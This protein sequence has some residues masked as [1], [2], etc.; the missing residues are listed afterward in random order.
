[1]S[2][3]HS[4][5]AASGAPLSSLQKMRICKLAEEAWTAKGRPYFTGDDAPF[6][7]SKHEALTLWRQ[8]EQKAAVDH[9]HLTTCTQVE[10]PRLMSHFLRALGRAEE[11]D[12]WEARGAMDPLRQAQVVLDRTIN[13][14]A[15]DLGDAESYAAAIARR[16]FGR[17]LAEL[18]RRQIWAIVFT[19]RNRAAKK[20]VRR[21]AAA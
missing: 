1:M 13:A 16:Q 18:D 21:R 12:R 15:S 17:S 6:S 2:L 11:A 19:L 20:G 8:E 14:A 3:D 4:I 9:R 5:P 7:L 10:F